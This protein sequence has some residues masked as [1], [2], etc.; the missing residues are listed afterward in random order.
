M[1]IPRKV[2]LSHW[3]YQSLVYILLLI[4]GAIGSYF[5]SDTQDVYLGL[6]GFVGT[7]VIIAAALSI[8]AR[9]GILP[10]FWRKK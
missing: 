8:C 4:A 6:A 10:E 1:K 3:K 2:I 7:L 5:W 9:L